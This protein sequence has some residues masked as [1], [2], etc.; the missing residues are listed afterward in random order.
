MK[1]TQRKEIHNNIPQLLYNVIGAAITVLLWG[2]ATG[3][4]EGPMAAFARN[5]AEAMPNA[6]GIIVGAT[7]TQ[8]LSRTLPGLM[9]GLENFGVFRGIHYE[10]GKFLAPKD[11][12]P[13]HRR[14]PDDAR[15][16][17][18]WFNGHGHFLVSQDRPGTSNGVRGC[19]LSGDEAKFLSVKKINEETMPVLS[20]DGAEQYGHLS[21]YL[22]ILFCS[23]MPNTAK[24]NWLLD[25]HDQMEPEIIESIL[26]VQQ[27]L[28]NY[29]MKYE[30]ASV[31]TRAKMEPE[32]N[33]LLNYL[34]ELRRGTIYVS[35]ASTL[36]NIHV[37][38]MEPIKQFFR[39]LKDL[40]LRLSIL[41][42]KIKKTEN[43]FYGLFDEDRF[44]YHEPNIGYLDGIELTKEN[45]I[46][47]DCRWDADCKKD[48]PLMI[49][50]DYNNSISSVVTGQIQGD[51]S[52]FLSSMYVLHPMQLR[53]LIHKWH[54]YYQHMHSHTVEY[55]YDHTA[56][57][58]R[59]ANSNLRFCDVVIK[60]L[61]LLGW[62]VIKR[63]V[64]KSYFHKTRWYLWSEWF[65]N[66]KEIWKYRF[67]YNKENCAQWAISV[68]GAEA[69]KKGNDIAK[70]KTNETDGVT[71][72]EEATHLSEA[73]D[74]LMQG[75]HKYKCKKASGKLMDIMSG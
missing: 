51:N 10:V 47:Q 74:T 8:I 28:S 52:R 57:Q 55:F 45:L 73:G 13:R 62:K 60:E 71:P 56:L 11:I 24:G 1:E 27:Q 12:L 36:D 17:I 44:G 42:Q 9:A 6:H 16:Y 38:G 26:I 39:T 58:G 34:N 63:Y 29:R 64:G 41:N 30:E 21:N 54:D 3:K 15:H 40:E 32:I 72:P 50:L 67:S 66:N 70:V 18:H 5:N 75:I 7:Y 65:L 48:K 35:Y 69:K 23:D 49:G 59:N 19:H 25:Y 43:S 37:L 53:H 33:R 61:E 31:H 2:R 20:G 14:A 68:Q 4:T 46:N 22:S